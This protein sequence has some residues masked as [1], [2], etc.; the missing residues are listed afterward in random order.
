MGRWRLG[1]SPCPSVP[2]V[3]E[4][5]LKADLWLMSSILHDP[6]RV[7]IRIICICNAYIYIYVYVYVYE[8]AYRHITRRV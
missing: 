6:M 2:K 3:G 8:Y 4:G 7:D 5:G 1:S